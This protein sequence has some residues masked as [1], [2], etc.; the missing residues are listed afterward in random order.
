MPMETPAVL[1]R[2]WKTYSFC[3][4]R[5]LSRCARAN[6]RYATCLRRW[7]KCVL[8]SRP[9]L[10]PSQRAQYIRHGVVCQAPGDP[11]W[12]QPGAGSLRLSKLSDG[13]RRSLEAKL[14]SICSK[15]L[16]AMTYDI[17]HTGKIAG[18]SRIKAESGANYSGLTFC[19]YVG[20]I[21]V[22]GGTPDVYR[23]LTCV[24]T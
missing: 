4:K 15:T 9:W 23:I 8:I 22:P 5:R 24:I 13:F 10:A 1:I 21:I 16:G 17:Q 6:D 18:Q 11:V 2:I 19:V 12:N 14:A 20:I 7:L 3:R